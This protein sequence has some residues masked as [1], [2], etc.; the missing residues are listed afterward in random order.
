MFN[1][2]RSINF[3]DKFDVR[4]DIFECLFFVTSNTIKNQ[5]KNQEKNKNPGQTTGCVERPYVF[6]ILNNLIFDGAW[7]HTKVP[8]NFPKFVQYS[9]FE[10]YCF[11][12]L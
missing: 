8:L 9:S 1:L 4:L 5:E 10:L 3:C 12:N 7:L 11:S 2:T 6:K